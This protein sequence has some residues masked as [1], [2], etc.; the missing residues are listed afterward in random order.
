VRLE[1]I[2]RLERHYAS[3]RRDPSIDG[4]EVTLDGEDKPFSI[5]KDQLQHI[6]QTIEEYIGWLR[7]VYPP[8]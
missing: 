4:Y 1:E 5:T 8:G 3:Y 2:K 7:S 6:G